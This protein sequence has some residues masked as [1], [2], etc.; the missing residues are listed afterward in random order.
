MITRSY[1]ELFMLYNGRKQVTN[2]ATWY[3]L[4]ML[5]E[6]MLSTCNGQIVNF[7]FSAVRLAAAMHYMLN[8]LMAAYKKNP[9]LLLDN[10]KCQQSW[11]L[12]VVIIVLSYTITWFIISS[13][14]TFLPISVNTHYGDV[15]PL[16]ACYLRVSIF[17]VV[18]TRNQKSQVE[19]WQSF[20][21]KPLWAIS[22]MKK[23]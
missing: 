4:G 9:H 6:N 18:S 22:H 19:T 15:M 13:Y 2:V 8:I 10:Y 3:H 1:D 14:N 20:I 11:A 17:S 12:P 23:T 7:S 5:L 21:V 16:S